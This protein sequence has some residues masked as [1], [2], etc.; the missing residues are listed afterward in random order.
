MINVGRNAREET[1]TD[2]WLGWTVCST[3]QCHSLLATDNHIQKFGYFVSSN[4][5]LIQIILISDVFQLCSFSSL[6]YQRQA[7][8]VGSIS[9]CFHANDSGDWTRVFV[10]P[11]QEIHLVQVSYTAAVMNI[12]ISSSSKMF[13]ARNKFSIT[14]RRIM[15][16]NT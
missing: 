2:K 5:Q 10:E 1:Q 3:P 9:N 15:A 7:D 11:Y 4:T 16:Q 6:A 12:N 14:S 8:I 13:D